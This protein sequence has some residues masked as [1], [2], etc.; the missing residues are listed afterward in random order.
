LEYTGERII[1]KGTIKEE[2]YEEFFTPLESIGKSLSFGCNEN[3]M[4]DLREH[5]ASNFNLWFL[6]ENRFEKE[7]NGKE[8]SMLIED[9]EIIVLSNGKEEETIET[10]SPLVT[11]VNIQESKARAI[12]Y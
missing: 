7:K 10:E 1:W 11:K 9:V 3:T 5:V 2:K 8:K 12:M 4:L 6:N